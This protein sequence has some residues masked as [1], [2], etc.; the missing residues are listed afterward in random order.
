MAVPGKPTVEFV[1]VFAWEVPAY[2]GAGWRHDSAKAGPSTDLFGAS[3]VDVLLVRVPES[4]SI[5][6]EKGTTVPEKR[7]TLHW[8]E[9]WR[10]LMAGESTTAREG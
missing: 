3:L 7:P 9:V 8:S 5:V 10:R 6:P 4:G 1:R 2:E